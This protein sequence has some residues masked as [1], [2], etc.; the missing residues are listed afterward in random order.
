MRFEKLLP[1]KPFKYLTPKTLLDLSRLGTT[2]FD[3]AS[4][5]SG[6]EISLFHKPIMSSA[7]SDLLF[8]PLSCPLHFIVS[9]PVMRLARKAPVPD[10][11]LERNG[12][13]IEDKFPVRWS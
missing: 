6:S 4:L 9:Y 7:N 12:L 10:R 3:L 13:A 8:R 2:G 1:E 11:R 5:S